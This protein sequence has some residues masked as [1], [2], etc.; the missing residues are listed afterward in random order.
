MI[1][2]TFSCVECSTNVVL[3]VPM[4]APKEEQES[5]LSWCPECE[6]IQHLHRVWVPTAFTFGLLTKRY[7]GQQ[8]AVSGWGTHSLD[9]GKAGSDLTTGRAQ[10]AARYVEPKVQGK[11]F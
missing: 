6:K 9:Y 3:D 10:E 11:D 5:Q 1:L 7:T 2:K 8:A 4:T